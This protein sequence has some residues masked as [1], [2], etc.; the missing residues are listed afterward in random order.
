MSSINWQL[1]RLVERPN[2]HWSLSTFPFSSLTTFDYTCFGTC[3]FFF[4]ARERRSLV[5][6]PLYFAGGGGGNEGLV[7]TVHV[8]NFN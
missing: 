6:R 3:E 8:Y 1:W 5:P 7:Y 2:S 4:Q